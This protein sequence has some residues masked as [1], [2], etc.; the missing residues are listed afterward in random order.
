[1]MTR[2]TYLNLLQEAFKTTGFLFK[3][4]KSSTTISGAGAMTFTCS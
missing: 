1:M 2:T 3:A 4:F